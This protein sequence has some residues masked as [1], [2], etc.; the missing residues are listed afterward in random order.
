MGIKSVIGDYS[1]I[2]K[3]RSEF[4]YK[5]LSD[6]DCYAIRKNKLY[7]IMDKYK[8]LSTKLKVKVTERYQST[9]RKN[10][11]EHKED[12]LEQIKRINKFEFQFGTVQFNQGSEEK[13]LLKQIE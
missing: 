7:Q 3:K 5:A 9:I 6:M 11:L 1:V 8:E 12:T 2:F 4:L 10:V 13:E